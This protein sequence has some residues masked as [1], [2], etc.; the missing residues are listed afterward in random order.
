LAS[1]GYD[2][3]KRTLE[4]EFKH[5]AL[6]RYLNVPNDVFQAFRTADSKGTF[7]N[8]RIKDSYAFVRVS[9]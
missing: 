6:Y 3:A 7:F 4:I 2:V 1:I 5:G 9:R 8:A